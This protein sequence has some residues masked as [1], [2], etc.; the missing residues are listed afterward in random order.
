VLE[1]QPL[2]RRLDDQL[3]RREVGQRRGD[4]EPRADVRRIAVEPALVHQLRDPPPGALRAFGGGAVDGIEH[5]R[6]GAGLG[7]ELG[8]PGSHR[9]G[10]DDADDL[11]CA[12]GGHAGISALMP[13]SARPMMSFWI[14]EVPS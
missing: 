3:A 4:L 13:V 11:R 10:A 6:P 8:D 2:R 9:P 1:L 5:Q 12:H 14:C 7:G